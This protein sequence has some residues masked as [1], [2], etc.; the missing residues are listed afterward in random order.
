MR[1]RNYTAAVGLA[2]I[3]ALSTVGCESGEA[4]CA[5]LTGAVTVDGTGA[6][7]VVVRLEFTDGTPD[8]QTTRTDDGGGFS[9]SVCPP[10]REERLREDVRVVLT[11]IPDGSTCPRTLTNTII[12][13]GE[14]TLLDFACTR[15]AE[16]CTGSEDE[17]GDGLIDC[18]DLQDCACAD[19]CIEGFIASC[20]PEDLLTDGGFE[21]TVPTFPFPMVSDQ[22]GGDI[23]QVVGEDV[24]G[25]AP[26]EGERAMQY[27]STFD[28][29]TPTPSASADVA[30]LIDTVDGDVD[31]RGRR[32]CGYAR[33]ARVEGD[34]DTDTQFSVVTAWYAGGP[35]EFM[36]F[37]ADLDPELDEEE[38]D[39]LDRMTQGI[40]STCFAT[41]RCGNG[42]ISVDDPETWTAA[43][44]TTVVPNDIATTA[45]VMVRAAE[46]NNNDG[47]DGDSE[48]DD[49][50]FDGHF[51]DGVHLYVVPDQCN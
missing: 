48:A 24:I 8:P 39:R 33:F 21:T 22:W 4:E 12:F 15:G 30:Q 1:Q 47:G 46:N 7:D 27:V 40:N 3:A 45:F 23:S 50:E 42:Q 38:R 25:F 51:V 28:T 10:N 36:G 49:P 44:S 29:P 35:V 41:G 37:V 16:I 13:S 18:D 11:S 6:S 9:F 26:F 5:T 43:S 32:I 14:E 17:D 34:E 20:D 31:L 2:V 19:A